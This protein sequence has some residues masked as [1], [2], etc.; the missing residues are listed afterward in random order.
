MNCRTKVEALPETP[1]MGVMDFVNTILISNS[2]FATYSLNP[3]VFLNGKRSNIGKNELDYEKGI[4]IV[5]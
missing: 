1:F 2:Y 5:K 3:Q 4:I